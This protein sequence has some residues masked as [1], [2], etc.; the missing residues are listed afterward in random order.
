M[1]EI[2]FLFHVFPNI[3]HRFGVVIVTESSNVNTGRDF[4]SFLC[5]NKMFVVCI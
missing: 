5:M 2:F 3:F 4:L 1:W